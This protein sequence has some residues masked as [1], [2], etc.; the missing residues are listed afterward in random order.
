MLLVLNCQSDMNTR[1]AHIM[2]CLIHLLFLIYMVFDIPTA[3][4]NEPETKLKY[5]KDC[6]ITPSY[7]SNRIMSGEIIP[8]DEYSWTASL[9]YGSESTY[10][11]CGGS[12]INSQYVLTAAHCVKGERVDALGGL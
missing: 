12:V 7:S 5:P 1:W 10:G 3:K 6:G 8:P 4:P 11:L 9:Q 2:I